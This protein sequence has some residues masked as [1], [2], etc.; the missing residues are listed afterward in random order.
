M[1]E[2][3]TGKILK[4]QKVTGTGFLVA[5]NIV[6]TAKHNVLTAEDIVDDGTI[7]ER[8][9]WFLITEDDPVRGK[10]MNLREAEKRGID[11]V[12]IRLE[13]KLSEKPITVLTEAEN[14]F[15]G[16]FC[17]IS[18]YPKEASG[19]IE[20]QGCIANGTEDKFIISVNKEDELQDY[21]GL[22]GSPVTIFGCVIGIVIRQENSERL[23]AL[24]VKY[25]R[26]VLK[27]HDVPFR[28]R[29]I[30]MH[31]SENTFDI[32]E[33]IEKNRQVI[34]MAGPRYSDE[35]NVK[36]KLYDR[37]QSILRKDEV[38]RIKEGI[39]NRSREC[40]RH[41][42]EFLTHGSEGEPCVLKESTTEIKKVIKNLQ[43]EMK[44]L[45]ADNISGEAF[46]TVYDNINN[47]G[48]YL[49][50]TFETEKERFEEKNGPGTFDNKSW[51]GFQASYMCTFPTR[52][53]DELK[54]A[55]DVLLRIMKQEDV[56]RLSI[57]EG[58]MIL[59][60]G[61]GGI[62]KTHLLCDIVNG[63]CKRMLPAGLLLGDMFGRNTAADDVIMNWEHPGGKIE[64]YFAW[65]DAYGEESDVYIP[66]CIDA[67]NETE[68]TDYWNRNL[69]LLQAKMGKYRNLKLII[70]CRGLYLREYLEE[71]KLE[72]M[73][74]LVHSGF[75]E[76]EERALAGFC[77]YYGVTINYETVCVPEFMNPLFLKMICE[78]AQEKEDKSVVVSDIGNLMEEFFMLKNKKI[79][80]QYSDCFSVRD[81]VVQTILEY[82]TEYIV[83]HDSYTI[84]WGKLRECVAEILEPFGV[85]D[86][87]SGIMKALI[88]ENLIREANDDGTKIAFSY[89]K[90]FEY[91][92]AES[93]VR[94]HG[95]ENTERIVQDVL[96]DKIT[97][98]T[99]EML[100]IVFFRNTGKEFID[101][102]DER[103]QEKVVETF[104]S[105]LYWRNES[106]IG[107]DTIAV[108]DRLLDSEKITDV[109]KTMAG[110][111]SVSTKKNIKVNAFYIHE[112]LCAMNN[113]DR[114]FYLSFYLLKQYDDMKTLSDLCERA[115]RLD[116]KTFPSDNISL[117]KIVL[118][119]GTGSNDT[120]LR[121]MASKGLTNLF[122]LYPDDMTEIAE[123]FADV[124]D[125]YIQERLWQAIYSAIILRAEKE[126]A[127]KMI[128]Y[129][130]TNI[131][132]EGK[133]PQN[134]LI[135]DYLRNI[136]EYAYYREWCSKEEV[137][138]VR[139]PY[140]S[141]KH[142][143]DKA[144]TEEMKDAYSSLYWNCQSSDF[145]VYTIPTEVSD[146]GLSRKDV[147][148]MVFEDI[149]R[150]GYDG[151][152]RDYDRWIDYTYGSLRNRDTQVERIGKKYQ[153]IYLYREM[154]NIYDNFLYAPKYPSNEI[155]FISPEQG[156]SF[157]EID[158]TIRLL[159]NDFKGAKLQYPY[160][161]FEDWADMKWFR[162]KDQEKYIAKLFTTN[163]KGE[164]Y[165][166]LQ[167]YQESSEPKKEDYRRV[168]IQIR[169]YFYEKGKKQ[170]LL[171]WFQKKNFDGRWMSE[172]TGGM[173]RNC[174]GEYP[175]SPD[176]VNYLGEEEEQNFRQE[177]PA[178]CY[179]IATVNDY[180]A[181]K[182]SPFCTNEDISY[183][184]PAV[185]LMEEMNLQWDG[186]YAYSAGGEKV[187]HMG[188]HDA[189]YIKKQYLLA[190]LE[191]H[192]LDI[193]WTVLGEK[194]KITEHTDFSGMAEFSY[195]Y[196]LDDSE[197]LIRNHE[198]SQIRKPFRR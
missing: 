14:D 169:S 189:M 26:N 117:W 3:T 111:L 171:K 29:T 99:L 196:C 122:R 104:M 155:E 116:D 1:R 32:K 45:N 124:E 113:Y 21:Q 144:C 39:E 70:S 165:Y 89:Q 168:W 61:Q 160:Y 54:E 162:K 80:R 25:I 64:Q 76:R 12:F 135:R 24:P 85:K 190:F 187:I 151:R 83:E 123:L 127:E 57:K 41:L 4:D 164:E 40:I 58:K 78:I 47:Q 170:E 46:Q 176:M 84:S 141:R 53:L 175:W 94:K 23:E 36:T 180:I 88:S 71:E 193:V 146:Y 93:Y 38:V 97:T 154:G 34:A 65:L 139:P 8:E 197:K 48:K 92:Y 49:K 131:V 137:E 167:S 55:L 87:T 50:K 27:C 178:P 91:Q 73:E 179:L 156:N 185:Y 174:L 66:I 98:G 134:V 79:S 105:G 166:V 5:E 17:K 159:E 33:Q 103:N 18:G 90:F 30:P 63:Y 130:T 140:K 152:C 142:I 31:L 177:K 37:L 147:G 188:D 133:W 56:R 173:Y 44:Q 74:K 121:D 181:E 35:L 62:G 20:L 192:N 19:K 95:T 191:E 86:K 67:V 68:D 136:F 186:E 126:Y 195:T 107:A 6:V 22:S 96:D 115:V 129:I 15:T 51:R 77:E 125:D 60:V 182:D 7:H 102:I 43:D 194:Q 13:E 132:D 109:K 9:I 82:V 69:P 112:K 81:Q 128:S 42:N 110:L 120:K 2:I 145:A 148:K 198:F 72:K 16:D 10:T 52:Y 100:Q 108:I 119:W 143:P 101:C 150:S 158:L 75:S 183:M 11:C 157:R 161:R 118:C 28:N 138:S 153:K 149:I 106:I 59:I 114:D 172:G 184:L 163:Y